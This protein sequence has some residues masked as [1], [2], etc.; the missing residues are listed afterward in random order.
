MHGEMEIRLLTRLNDFMYRITR[1]VCN[2]YASSTL[3]ATIRLAPYLAQHLQRDSAPPHQMQWT[4]ITI[5]LP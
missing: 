3:F 5:G 4:F 2:S 1:E